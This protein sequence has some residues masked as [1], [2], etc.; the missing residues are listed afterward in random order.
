MKTNI[1]DQIYHKETINK[2]LN[3]REKEFLR[4]LGKGKS[5]IQIEQE[6]QNANL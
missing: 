1:I 6:A 4:S 2:E 3:L 5:M